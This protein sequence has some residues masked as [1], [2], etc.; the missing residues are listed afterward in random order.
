MPIAGQDGMSN[1]IHSNGN[2]QNIN[3]K[4]YTVGT[5]IKRNMKNE[6]GRRIEPITR[7][8]NGVKMPTKQF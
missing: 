5:K 7:H 8:I 1:R 6:V 3:S 2:A 4:D